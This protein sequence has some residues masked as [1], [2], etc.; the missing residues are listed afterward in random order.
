LGTHNGLLPIEVASTPGMSTWRLVKN[1][2]IAQLYEFAPKLFSPWL[3]PHISGMFS[4]WLKDSSRTGRI[5]F[6]HGFIDAP[7]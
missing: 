5:P 2:S 4:R 6:R 1:E 3:C 7:G